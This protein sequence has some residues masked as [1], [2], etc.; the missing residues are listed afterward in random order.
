[1]YVDYNFSHYLNV[2]RAIVE[3][4]LLLIENSEND[5]NPDFWTRYI[6]KNAVPEFQSWIIFSIF[7]SAPIIF[8]VYRIFLKSLKNKKSN[9]I[10]LKI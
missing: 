5:F 8:V 3:H 6:E 7:F 1:M 2:N 10:S 4:G 9:R